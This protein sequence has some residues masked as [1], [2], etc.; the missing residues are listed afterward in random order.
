MARAA[1]SGVPRR[2]VAST[3]AM[4]SGDLSA[5][6]ICV[7]AKPICDLANRPIGRV[8]LSV[9]LAGSV[10]Q[11]TSKMPFA[12]FTGPVSRRRLAVVAAALA[13][14]VGM[15]L[16]APTAAMA[17]TA[18]TAAEQ[19]AY[20]GLHRAAAL[21]DAAQIRKLLA[22]HADPNARDAAGRTPLHVAAFG[23][24]YDAVRALV[25]G[26]ADINAL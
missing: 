22:D 15:S 6:I 21:G 4:H 11:R 7:P 9:L 20:T 24:R 2:E 18:P 3:L 25:A 12:L 17:Q 1:F 23:S 16:H 8:A 14:G 10:Q 13:A 19:A 5:A 26:G